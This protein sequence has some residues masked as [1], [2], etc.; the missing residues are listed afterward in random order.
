MVMSSG[1]MLAVRKWRRAAP[2]RRARAAWEG[3]TITVSS[4]GI[5]IE[6]VVPAPDGDCPR[7]PVGA[8]FPSRSNGSSVAKRYYN[9]R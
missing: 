9:G 8:P 2:R 5:S 4:D 3:M 6:S 1:Q 7:Q